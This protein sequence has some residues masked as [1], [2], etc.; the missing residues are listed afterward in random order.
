M[1][2]NKQTQKMME[3]IERENEIIIDGSRVY[4]ENG[5]VKTIFSDEIQRNGFM[6]IEEADALLDATI[7]LIYD[8]K[9]N[10]DK[11]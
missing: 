11:G 8:M 6:T 1:H 3:K 5:E 7:D 10:A 9:E 2:R 4:V